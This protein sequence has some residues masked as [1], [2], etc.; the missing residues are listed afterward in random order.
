MSDD[1]SSGPNQLR[2]WRPVPGY[3]QLALSLRGVLWSC[4]GD[5]WQR[6]AIKRGFAVVLQN[7]RRVRVH[8]ASL[9]K[10]IDL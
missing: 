5:R 6:V 2:L 10:G 4:V 9:L 7:G 3:P 1:N 8:L